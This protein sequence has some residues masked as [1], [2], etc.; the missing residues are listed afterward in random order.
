MWPQF[1]KIYTYCWTRLKKLYPTICF[2]QETHLTGNNT[3]C[4]EF[5]MMKTNLSKEW[6]SKKKKVDTTSLI[7]ATLESEQIW[8]DST[9]T[10][11]NVH[12]SIIGTHVLYNKPG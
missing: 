1:T 12:T 8:N 2:L 6:E 3:S 10:I 9:I 4:P 7:T 5:Q 11:P